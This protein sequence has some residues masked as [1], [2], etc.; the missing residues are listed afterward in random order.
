MS[1]QEERRRADAAR[2]LKQALDTFD[3]RGFTDLWKVLA[4]QRKIRYDEHLTAGFS[5]EQALF[6]CKD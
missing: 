5:P 4:Q 6:L 1:D 2:G 3:P